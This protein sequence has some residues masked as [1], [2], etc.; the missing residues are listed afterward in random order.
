MF[1]NSSGWL[2]GCGPQKNEV[3]FKGHGLSEGCFLSVGFS[4]CVY[5]GKD[6]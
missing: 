6:C 1:V 4:M 5:Y 2:V 3:E